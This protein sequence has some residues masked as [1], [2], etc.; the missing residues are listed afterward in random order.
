MAETMEDVQLETPDLEQ[1]TPSPDV[2]MAPSIHETCVLSGNS[3]SHFSPIPS[4]IAENMTTE[5]CLGID[6]AGRGP[7]LGPMVYGLFYLPTALHHSRLADTH[8]SHDSKVLTPAVRTNLMRTLCTSTSDLHAS[9]GWATRIMSARDISAAMLSPAPYNLNAQAM[10]AT[11][12]LITAVLAQGVNVTEIY[13]D[14]IGRP[15]TYQKKLERSEER[16]VG[17]ECPV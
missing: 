6:E 7:V 4:L 3:Y 17:K 5:C 12:S 9:C 8:H 1:E 13:I 10:D 15:E 2:F 11:I 16:R 14:T